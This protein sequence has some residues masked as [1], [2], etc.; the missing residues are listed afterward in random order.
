MTYGSLFS[1]CGGMDIGLDR[2]GLECRWQVEIDKTARSVLARHWPDVP[3]FEDVCEVGKREL[4][5]V[6]VI[7]GGWPCQDLSV[8]GQRKGLQHGER[9]RLFY[10]LARIAAELRPRYL[11]WE[12]VP[13]LLSSDDG[14]DFARV[15]RHLG[16]CGYRGCWRIC[17]AQYFG[18]PQQRRRV[19]GVFSFGDFTTE[20]CA[21]IL[22]LTKGLQRNPAESG[23]KRPDVASA[24]TRSL[25]SG[26]IDDN[27]AQA[28]H[29]VYGGNDTRGPRAA[30]AAA[31]LSTKA[32][33]Q[34]FETEN[35][36][37]AF[38]G[39]SDGSNARNATDIAPPITN[40]HGALGFV[41]YAIQERAVSENLA[42]GPGGLGIRPD[43]AYTL[44]ARNKVQAVGFVQN[45]R[46]EIRT[47]DGPIGSLQ[48]EPGMKQQTYLNVGT[49]LRRL[50]PIE[51]ERLMS[52]P[53]DFT[54]YRADGSEI[55]DG[56]RYKMIGNGVVANCAEWIGRRLVS[57]LSHNPAV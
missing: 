31:A 50:T 34:D 22:A 56:P 1:G 17:D 2:A 21:E 35:F 49:V 10:E 9:S 55:A 23:K 38:G 26:G 7:A 6:D 29:L 3:K 27:D 42:N 52:W 30:A 37:L 18:V 8:A 54:K 53:D 43:T 20:R 16:D 25:G 5:K 24:I 45:Q 47:F 28:G 15:L 40:R 46:D 41:A 4:C 13:G 51:C 33:R 19:F 32:T 11:V 12:N 14:R 39:E 48:A 36:V 44:E 57:N